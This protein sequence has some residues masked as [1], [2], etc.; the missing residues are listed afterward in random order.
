M[1]NT[2]GIWPIKP[3]VTVLN[4]IDTLDAEERVFLVDE[5]KAGTGVD[6]MLMSGATGEGTVDVLRAL[7][8]EIDADKIRQNAPEEQE[9]WQP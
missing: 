8:R 3:R 7:K 1:K 2:A 4:K 9:P 5:I 6:V